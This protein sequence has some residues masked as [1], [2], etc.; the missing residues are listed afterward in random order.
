MRPLPPAQQDQAAGGGV[1][2]AAHAALQRGNSRFQRR[3]PRLGRLLPGAGAGGHLLHRVQL[4]AAHQV[5]SRRIVSS[6]RRAAAP[7]PPRAARQSAENAPPATPARSS[8]KRGRS[9]MAASSAVPGRS[10]GHR[11]LCR[12]RHPPYN[13]AAMI[14]VTGGAGFIGSNLH[15]ALA[16]RGPETV[17]VD[18]L[19]RR[20]ANGATSPS[21]RRRASSRPDALDDF[22]AASPPLELIFHLGAI[23][24]TT[25]TRRRPGLGRPMSSCRCGSGT[26]APTRG[27]RLIY[28]SSAATY[29]DGARGFDDDPA[30]C[31]RLRPL[32]LYGWTKHAFDLRVARS[33]RRAAGRA[34]RNG[35]G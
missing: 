5:D 3:E 12:P 17:V 34:R 21:T 4:L 22:L 23:S 24:E 8:K 30:R 20:R 19:R 18:R 29:G 14:L 27:V 7:P 31:A 1:P 6:S 35:R 9:V 33:W 32:N 10:L 25:A 28:A 15:A 13:A 11:G 26:G 2:G 16:G